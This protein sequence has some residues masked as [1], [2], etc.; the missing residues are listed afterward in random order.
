MCSFTLNSI[1]DALQ[2]RFREE[3]GSRSKKSNA[4]AGPMHPGKCP[5]AK[6]TNSELQFLKSHPLIEDQA[7]GDLLS[8]YVGERWTA[9][10]VDT[11][12]GPHRNWTVYFV[13]TDR[14][15]VLRYLSPTGDL[16]NAVLLKRQ[17][18]YDSTR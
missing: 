10:S 3:R 4:P 16:K 11:T 15:Q 9:V 6:Y 12:A 8:T 14:G 7:R 17:D 2:G 5:G 18:V 1:H 13:G